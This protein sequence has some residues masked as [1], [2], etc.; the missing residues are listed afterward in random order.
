MAEENSPFD[1][2]GRKL[3]F[4][5]C[6]RCGTASEFA[7]AMP[8]PVEVLQ[9]LY[10]NEFPTEDLP[11]DHHPLALACLHKCHN[12][13]CET[14]EWGQF[15]SHDLAVEEAAKEHLAEKEKA[16]EEEEEEEEKGK[17]SLDELLSFI[18]PN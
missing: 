7:D 2:I 8:V 5:P 15:V 6:P 13:D 9:F 17:H 1:E 11:E 16:E 14:E 10:R 18:N 12:G 4:A 3:I